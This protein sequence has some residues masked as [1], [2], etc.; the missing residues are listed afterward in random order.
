MYVVHVLLCYLH[1]TTL[2]KA[3]G[4]RKQL[5]PR[6]SVQLFF[7]VQGANNEKDLIYTLF[8]SEKPHLL[9]IFKDYLS[10]LPK[11]PSFY[12]LLNN[13]TVF[14]AVERSSTTVLLPMLFKIC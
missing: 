1:K 3:N 11:D 13:L 2:Q 12:L 5:R 9:L 10:L 4:V 6:A 8:F 7:V 14:L